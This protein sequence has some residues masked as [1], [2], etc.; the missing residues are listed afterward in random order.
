MPGAGDRSF[1]AVP[2]DRPGDLT[3][4]DR[5]RD[6]GDFSVNYDGAGWD[7]PDQESV[8]IFLD[9]NIE[10]RSVLSS[11]D[12]ELIHKKAQQYLVESDIASAWK[13]LLAAQD[14]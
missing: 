10:V 5:L 7:I 4:L 6:A 2:D 12:T 14:R 3:G 13:V 11:D 8:K 9:Q 1:V